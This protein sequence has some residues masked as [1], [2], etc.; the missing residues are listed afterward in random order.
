MSLRYLL[1][2]DTQPVSFSTQNLMSKAL[3]LSLIAD[4]K[5]LT[6]PKLKSKANMLTSN[7]TTE[8]NPEISSV[9]LSFK[10]TVFVDGVL[11]V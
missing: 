3:P 4:H 7:R 2:F 6:Q 1:V 11:L 9:Q 8:L 10:T 5:Q